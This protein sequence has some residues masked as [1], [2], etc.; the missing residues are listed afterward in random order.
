MRTLGELWDRDVAG[1]R[2][3]GARASGAT[4]A[5]ELRAHG[6]DFSFTPVLD[7]DYGAS[8]VIGDRAFHRNPNAVAHLARRSARGLARG[9]HGG[10]RQAFSRSRLRRGRFAHRA[11]GRRAPAGR[12]SPPTIS[13]RSR[14][15]VQ[16]GLEA[17]MPA[18]VVYPAVDAEPAGFSRMLAAGRSCAGGSA[19]TDSSSPTISAWPARTARATSSRART[20]RSPPAATWC[21]PATTSRRRTPARALASRRWTRPRTT[22]R[23][24]GSA[25]LRVVGEH[26]RRSGPRR[27]A[28][29]YNDVRCTAP[30]E[31]CGLMT[32]V[33]LRG[34]NR[35]S[36][37]A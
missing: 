33:T 26:R 23:E 17:I 24:D 6:V 31:R 32:Q 14:A 8:A 19:S 4:I 16:R 35:A 12:R 7:L 21:S 1:A 2:A 9:R 20:R 28:S 36:G 29:V 13:C 37:P 3:R 18:H 5:G 25:F 27:K 30:R 11:A 10:G 15:L 34:S 22:C